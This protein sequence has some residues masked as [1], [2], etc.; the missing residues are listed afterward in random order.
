L[1]QD[2]RLGKDTSRTL[3]YQFCFRESAGL[4]GHEAA[5]HRWV[6]M[7]QGRECFRTVQPWHT[8]IQEDQSNLVSMALVELDGFAAVGR[9]PDDKALLPQ[10]YLQEITYHRLIIHHEDAPSLILGVDRTASGGP[11]GSSRG[12]L[13]WA[14]NRIS[15]PMTLANGRRDHFA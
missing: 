14:L 3:L 9:R 8:H 15:R 13:L 4:A 11:M 1:R 5:D 6:E 7:P 2:K 12:R 10:D